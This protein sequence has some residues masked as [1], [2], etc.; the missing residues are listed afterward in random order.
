MANVKLADG[1][2]QKLVTCMFKANIAL[3]LPFL[4]SLSSTFVSF[5][6]TGSVLFVLSVHFGIK[7]M[8]TKFEFF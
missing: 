3:D 2:I 5:D 8:E 7:K 4:F 1:Y 6:C